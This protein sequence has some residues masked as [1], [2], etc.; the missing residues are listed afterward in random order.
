MPSCRRD[1]GVFLLLLSRIKQCGTLTDRELDICKDI[2]LG[3]DEDIIEVASSIVMP[4]KLD[5]D[6]VK[7]IVRFLRNK[8]EVYYKDVID[9]VFNGASLEEAY[10][11]ASTWAQQLPPGAR[12]EGVDHHTL[13]YGEVDFDAFSYVLKVACRGAG[14]KGRGSNPR[15]AG[16][17]G[18]VMPSMDTPTYASTESGGGPSCPAIGRSRRFI[19]LGHGSGRAVIMVH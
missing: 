13:V 2:V 17:L 16:A 4:D 7:G 9:Q 3:G 19:D 18:G 10:E 6:D 11:R 12:G 15:A 5:D 1:L 14:G 8:L